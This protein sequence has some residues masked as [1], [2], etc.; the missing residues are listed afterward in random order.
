MCIK[1]TGTSERI[2][3]G[4]NGWAL[5]DDIDAF[6]DKVEEIYN[7]KKNFPNE[8]LELRESTRNK[9]V[10]LWKDIANEYLALYQQR[11]E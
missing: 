10:P 7:M 2:T 6:A 4:V 5:D 1:N 3:D 11:V 8:Y 9:P